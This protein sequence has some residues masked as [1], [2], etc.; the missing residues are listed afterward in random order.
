[1]LFLSAL[2]C[3]CLA[4]TATFA[5]LA[6]GFRPLFITILQLIMA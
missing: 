5:M 3:H 1:V 2:L 4:H 6:A